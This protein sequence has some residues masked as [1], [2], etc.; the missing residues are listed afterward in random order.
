[1]IS[2]FYQ[3]QEIEINN[4]SIQNVQ[5]RNEA[6]LKDDA[7]RLLAEAV[8]SE[9]PRTAPD[10]V[11][12]DLFMDINQDPF[13]SATAVVCPGLFEDTPVSSAEPNTNDDVTNFSVS[14]LGDDEVELVS[15][16]CMNSASETMT[17]R[18]N[19]D[20]EPSTSSA[21]QNTNDDSSTA[22]TKVTFEVRTEPCISTTE[23]YHN[24]K[25]LEPEVVA[26]RVIKG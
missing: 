13:A 5:I 7:R 10:S 1:M 19:V 17:V 20:E 16:E 22:L 25:L 14:I 15:R 12:M 23:H 21:G 2:H 26:T 11:I 18:I 3:I 24:D 6:V 4:D 9:R 8:S